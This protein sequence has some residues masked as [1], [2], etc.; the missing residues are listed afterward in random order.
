MKIYAVFLQYVGCDG[1]ELE[2][3]EVHMFLDKKKAEECRDSY[4]IGPDSQD[5]D[6]ARIFE[7][8]VKE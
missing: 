1:F 6:D 3:N 4:L 2:P 8:E 7:Y 5:I